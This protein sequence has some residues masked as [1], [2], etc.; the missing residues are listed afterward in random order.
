MPA[1]ERRT[2]LDLLVAAALA[3]VT[4]AASVTLWWISDAR[5][6]TLSTAP[7]PAR[8]VSASGQLP[9]ALAEA[10]RA[11]SPAT[12][13][14]L[15]QGGVAVTGNGGVVAGH[16]LISGAVRWSYQRDRPLCT[17]AAALRQAVAVYQRGETCSEVTALEW[18]DGQRG[19]QRTGPVEAPTRL[20]A[21][22]D[23]VA[24]SGQ[25]YLEVWRSDLVRTLT[26]GRLPTPVKP[27]A[28][29]RPEC[30]H[31]SMALDAGVKSGG[32]LAVVE[33]CPGERV[34]L[35]LQ[36]SDPK[37][38]DQPE[39]G[40]SI[41]LGGTQAR[42]VALSRD[43]VA[44]ALPDPARLVVLDKQGNAVAEHPLAVPS[45][46]LRGNPPGGLVEVTVTPTAVYWFTGSATVALDVADLRPQWTR[47][48]TLGAGS[49]VAGRLLLPVPG[50]LAVLDT[51]TGQQVS[52]LPVDRGGYRGPVGTASSGNVV[53]EQRGDTLVALR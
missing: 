38:P 2:R 51:T 34:R 6:T 41:M 24:A 9:P 42:V 29:P 52:T 53:L 40:F 35:T 33:Q 5:S 18:A 16:D 23:Q 45:S 17:V 25:N 13:V 7:G 39:V 22:G 44:V 3:V 50:A 30:T 31:G 49:E 47:P 48:D 28:Q 36:R 1:P 11:P 46:D 21:S 37:E 32:R 20:A 26:Y 8:Q 27:G 4:L 19:A 14:P 43:W 10:W 15:V 12:P